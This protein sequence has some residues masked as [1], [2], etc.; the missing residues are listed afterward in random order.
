M[1]PRLEFEQELGELQNRMEEMGKQMKSAYTKLFGALEMRDEDTIA[2]LMK[3]DSVISEMERY[4]ES[5]CL[6]MITKQQPVARDLRLVTATLKAV[7]DIER[8]GDH[9]CD[10]AELFMRLLTLNKD[11]TEKNF[12]TKYSQHL[13][14][15]VQETK[16]MIHDSINAF[17]ERNMDS[18]AEVIAYDDVVDTLFNKVKNDL[19]EAL[20]FETYA[21]DEAV[22]ILM[23]AKYLE[24]IADHAVNIGEWEIFRETGNIG[25]IRLF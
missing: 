3:N 16:H 4:I 22:D 9:V 17:T 19:I 2:L 20:K 15:M 11:K 24:K 13:P 25:D 10:M 8:M 23:I 12:L 7:T 1:S 21:A 14:M 6:R 18:A 5:S